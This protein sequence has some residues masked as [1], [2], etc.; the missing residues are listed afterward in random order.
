M[1]WEG[2]NIVARARDAMGATNPEEAAE[3]TEDA[4]ASAD[5]E[6]EE[7]ATDAEGDDATDSDGEGNAATEAPINV[8]L[9]LIEARLQLLVIQAEANEQGLEWVQSEFEKVRTT[10]SEDLAASGE[11]GEA[12]WQGLEE[13][14]D[15]L[16]GQI[17]AE[18]ENIEQDI[19]DLISTLKETSRGL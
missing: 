3:G 16:A 15:A 12:I 17:E 8:Q 4:D 1:V 19:S 13:S 14:F 7:A 18:S 5:A 6:G 10:L 9:S 2:D 11:E